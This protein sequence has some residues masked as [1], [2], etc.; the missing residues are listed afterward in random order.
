MRY[1]IIFVAMLTLFVP[2]SQGQSL[3]ILGAID[4]ILATLEDLKNKVDLITSQIG[5]Q[6]EKLNS[7]DSALANITTQWPELQESAAFVQNVR[8]Q[9][10]PII[11]QFP[12]L[13]AQLETLDSLQQGLSDRYD[14]LNTSIGSITESIS[15]DSENKLAAVE[16]EV[17]SLGTAMDERDQNIE[18]L[19]NEIGSLKTMNYVLFGLV[20]LIGIFAIIMT[21]RSQSAQRQTR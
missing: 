19:N 12:D 9:L 13:Q 15:F 8:S 1:T 2:V 18:H 20:F 6:T 11:S 5:D 17:L 14:S 3:D 21:R 4:E 10:E 16:D 7:L